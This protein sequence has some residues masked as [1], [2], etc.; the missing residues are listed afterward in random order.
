MTLACIYYF[1]TVLV[2]PDVY[3]GCSPIT[4]GRPQVYTTGQSQLDITSSGFINKHSQV[5]PSLH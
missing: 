2:C 5:F 1:D 3:K 4:S